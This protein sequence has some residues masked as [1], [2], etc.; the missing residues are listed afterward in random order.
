MA[1]ELHQHVDADNHICEFGGEGVAQVLYHCTGGPFAIDTNLLEG[2]QD[3]VLQGS[4]RDP[5]SVCPEKQRSLGEKH[6]SPI[7]G[8]VLLTRPW[9]WR[10]RNYHREVVVGDG[11]AHPF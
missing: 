8:G 3:P 7:S 5:L 9:Q 2:A 4:A 10:S 11:I 1:E 6:I